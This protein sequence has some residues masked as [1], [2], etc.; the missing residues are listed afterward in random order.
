MANKL[1]DF[2]FWDRDYRLDKMSLKDLTIAYFLYP[3]IQVYIVLGLIS[4]VLSINLGVTAFQFITSVAVSIIL[5]PVFW[6]GLHRYVLHGRLLYKFPMTAKVWKRI[7]F[8]H[9]RDPHDLKVLFGALYT[10]L[11]TILILVTPIGWIIGGPAAAASAFAAGLFIT[12]F[13]EYCHCI[14]HLRYTPKSKSLKAIKKLHLQHHFHDENHNFGITN[15]F[16]DKLFGTYNED[17][18]ELSR[19]ET[20]FN[21]GYTKEQV[22]KYPWVARM[23]SDIDE[24]DA[25]ESGVQQRR[26]HQLKNND[27]EQTAH[28]KGNAEPENDVGAKDKDVADAA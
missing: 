19:S 10:T 23:T 25:I 13:Y 8:D 5:Y 28:I 3:A 6:Y 16:V 27:Q 4:A 9:H 18:K 26:Y 21:L 12:C 14:Q 2:K 7:H 22:E 20:V 1:I 24:A 15:F 17:A 11:P